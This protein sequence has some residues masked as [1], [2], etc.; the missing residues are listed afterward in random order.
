MSIL[1]SLPIYFIIWWI[2]LFAVLPWGVRTQEEDGD[3]IPGTAPSAPVRPRMLH[4]VIATTIIAT[5]V[6]T[7]FYF[8]RT[9]GFL[10]LDTFPYLPKFN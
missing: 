4:K 5:I 2:V 6:F 9:S 7:A 10:A 3:I 1:S 8:A